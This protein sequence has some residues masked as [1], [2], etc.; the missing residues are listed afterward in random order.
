MSQL[1]SFIRVAALALACALV[2]APTLAQDKV[3]KLVVGYPPGAGSDT[4]TRL[5]AD[6]MRTI[7]GQPVIVENKTGASGRLAV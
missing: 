2:A 4:L 6:R 5:L 3:T 1:L 7:L